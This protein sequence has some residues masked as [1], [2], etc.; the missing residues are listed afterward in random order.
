[1]TAWSSRMVGR[2]REGRMGDEACVTRVGGNSVGVAGLYR[3]PAC[4]TVGV[5]I[6]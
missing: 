1:M 6:Q 2:I 3:A 5:V 4:G